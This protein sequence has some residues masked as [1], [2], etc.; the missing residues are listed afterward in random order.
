M[1]AVRRAASDSDPQGA[2]RQG[3][4]NPPMK[5]GEVPRAAGLQ[6]PSGLTTLP[7]PVSSIPNGN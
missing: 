1:K 2:P 4:A 7:G 6:N 3:K 5:P